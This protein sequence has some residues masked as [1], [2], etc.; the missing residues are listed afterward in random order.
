MLRSISGTWGWNRKT[1]GDH[2]P[3]GSLALFVMGAISINLF[4]LALEP[5]EFGRFLFCIASCTS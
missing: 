4:I 2:P 3:S 1:E 5:V